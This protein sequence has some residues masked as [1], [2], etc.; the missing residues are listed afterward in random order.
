MNKKR[1]AIIII[2]IILSVIFISAA[3]Y[4]CWWFGG[5]FHFGFYGNVTIWVPAEGVWYCNE[6]DMQLA[7]SDSDDSYIVID[8]EKVICAVR[9]NRGSQVFSLLIQENDVPNYKLG[10]VVFTGKYVSLTDEAFTVKDRNS[11]IQ[12]VFIKM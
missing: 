4:M 9:N 11:G 1:L 2:A 7:F 3:L 6:L 10:D 8:G 12:Y 5:L